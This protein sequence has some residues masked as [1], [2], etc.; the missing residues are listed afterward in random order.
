MISTVDC[1]RNP[2]HLLHISADVPLLLFIYFLLIILHYPLLV[3]PSH[4]PSPSPSPPLS[5]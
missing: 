3:I 5:W 1:L 2:V 4:N